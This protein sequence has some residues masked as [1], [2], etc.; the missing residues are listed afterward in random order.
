MEPVCP[1]CRLWGIQPASTAALE[2][3]HG[4]P[5]DVRKF[6]EDS[7]IFLTF[8]TPAAGYNDLCLVQAHIVLLAGLN[9]FKDSGTD[10]AFRR[11]NVLLYDLRPVV[12]SSLRLFKCAGA[13]GAH[14]GTGICA[15]DLS[16][17]VSAKC[18][19]LPDH[20]FGLLIYT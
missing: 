20:I 8:H 3:P 4:S 7:K 10:L 14:L 18:G 5:K 17:Q 2:H 19:A 15:E 1:T 16:V 9:K 11:M 6:P 13:A 12:F